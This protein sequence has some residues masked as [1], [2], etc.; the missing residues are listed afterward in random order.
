MNTYHTQN[1]TPDFDFIQTLVDECLISKAQL[2]IAKKEHRATGNTIESCLL[3][4]GFITEH[5]L[6]TYIAKHSGHEK[7][8]LENIVLDP[9]LVAKIPKNIAQ[10][11]QVVPV[12]LNENRL[13]LA[14]ADVYD[15]VAMDA[16][17]NH[18]YQSIKI[19][20]LVANQGE[21][22][23]T[24][25]AYYNHDMNLEQI[26]QEL[27]KQRDD[28][29]SRD[30]SLKNPITRMVNIILLEAVSKNASD[31]HFQPS[32]SFVC[33]KF[34]IDGVLE[35]RTVFH[36]DYW[37]KIC[38]R[39]KI[40]AKMN[41]A[42]SRKPQNGRFTYNA[43]LRAVDFRV[44]VHPT[45]Q[46]ENIVLRVLDKENSLLPLNQ[47]GFSTANM[48]RLKNLANQPQG[49]VILTGPT[50]TGKT[51]TLYSILAYLNTARR[52]I[53]T[54]EDPIEYQIP[55]IRQ[56]AINQ[57]GGTTFAQGV[58]SLL[59]QDPD[60]IFVGEIRDE[61]TA[62]MALRAVMTGHQ[63]LTTL[64]T[65]DSFGVIPRLADL[66]I[67]PKNLAGYLTGVVSQ[68]LI[69]LLCQ[70]CKSQRAITR[71]EQ[72]ILKL[73]LEQKLFAAQGCDECRHTGFKGRTA[74]TEVLHFTE[75]LNELLINNAPLP[76]L[77]KKAKLTG[78]K[79]LKQQGLQKIL[80]GKT[81]LNELKRVI[82]IIEP[83]EADN[84]KV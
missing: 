8:S 41:I 42:E 35:Q 53:M 31:I 5:A 44:S 58:R 40:M 82:S 72:K 80:E 62:T 61:D 24:L 20:P 47:L 15:V 64:H 59:R 27:E 23:I 48:D 1:L 7:I 28:S 75:E 22:K 60:I 81:T 2:A 26:F 6:A 17:R 52:N 18:F 68:R 43:G 50:G 21:M 34:R 49:L 11:H 74:I 56:S 73:H 65:Q 79:N 12:A 39:L 36:S 51:T 16:V 70:T 63:V 83:S 54:L 19:H 25:N 13:T 55:S 29:L 4:L 76:K 10:Q 33:L 3:K 67:S 77:R 57:M 46:G 78:F 71:S 66:G 9:D 32:K 30:T 37:P 84:A 69:R 14:M 38:V 45:L